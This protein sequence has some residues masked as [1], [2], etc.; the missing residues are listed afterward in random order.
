MRSRCSWLMLHGSFATHITQCLKAHKD[1]VQLFLVWTC[2]LMLPSL[3]TDMKSET[4]S[5]HQNFNTSH[6]NYDYLRLQ[7]GDMALTWKDGIPCKL[8]W[9]MTSVYTVGQSGFNTEQK[10]SGGLNICDHVYTIYCVD[11]VS[12]AP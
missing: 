1:Q 8:F 3:L 5:Q 7:R 10:I 6:E 11:I 9:T 12:L 4:K 2:C